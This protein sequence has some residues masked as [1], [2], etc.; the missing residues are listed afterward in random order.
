[1]T[2]QEI[3]ELYNRY[4]IPSYRKLPYAFAKGKGSKIYDAEGK[5]YLDLFPGWGV[6]GLGHCHPAVVNAI[7]EQAKNLLHLPN[8]YYNELQGKLAEKLIK[9]SFDGKAFFANSGAEANEGAVKL[10]RRFGHDSGRFELIAMN[11]SF[12]GRTLAGIAL[13]GQSKYQEG[14]EPMPE[15]FKHVPFNYIKAVESA[16]TDKTAAIM[17]EP[18]H[19]E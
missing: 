7:K 3:I 17:L 4:V 6:S 8:N 19:G 9:N 10:A 1:M 12:H 2:T 14:F 11:G 15:G 5:E 18:I 13:T 16:I